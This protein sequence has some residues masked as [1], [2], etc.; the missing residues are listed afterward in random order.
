MT[1]F[2]IAGLPPREGRFGPSGTIG[3]LSDLRVRE[4]LNGC[5][6]RG[7]CQR[8]DEISEVVCRIR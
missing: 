6:G 7:G 1:A 5:G 4:L 2:G 3:C 8:S